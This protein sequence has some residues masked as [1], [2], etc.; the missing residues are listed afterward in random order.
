MIDTISSIY[1]YLTTTARIL[2]IQVAR[3]APEPQSMIAYSF[4]DEFEGRPGLL[5]H[6]PITP[7]LDTDIRW[8]EDQVRRQLDAR[9]RG[10]PE[11]T[12]DEKKNEL[13]YYRL[14]SASFT[15]Q[16]RNFII[17]QHLELG[18]KLNGLFGSA[19]GTGCAYEPGPRRKDIESPYF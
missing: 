17:G 2:D 5:D 16:S 6:V 14:K 11:I 3:S 15:T 12:L 18:T 19:K 4:V 13:L 7:M 1:M 10:L 9:C 8:W